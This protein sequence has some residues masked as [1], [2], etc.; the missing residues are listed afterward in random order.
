MGRRVI[1]L[2]LL[3]ITTAIAGAASPACT[4]RQPRLR[5]PRADIF[6]EQQEQW[7]GDAQSEMV[8][9]RYTLLPEV[10]ST[11]LDEIGKRLLDQL[12]P[13]Q[14]HYTFRVFESP[15]LRAFSLA[16][17][18]IYI[19]R[20]LIMDARSEDELAAMLAQ[21][22]GRVYIRHSAS[23]VTLRLDKLMHVKT[24]GDRTDVY[25]QIRASAQRPTE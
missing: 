3:L 4:L 21:E 23:K 16:G 6:T 20:K 11:Y 25:E 7:L 22:I 24:L 10:E 5:V 8:E 17:G 14:M 18:H 2:L 19:S 1:A 15:D 12:P 9:P 13:T